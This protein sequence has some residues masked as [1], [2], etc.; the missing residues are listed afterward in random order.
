MWYERSIFCQSWQRWLE[1]WTKYG[2]VLRTGARPGEA[3]TQA[4]RPAS[5]GKGE[6]CREIKTTYYV[7]APGPTCL[8]NCPRS[9]E[10]WSPRGFSGGAGRVAAIAIS[11]KELWARRYRHIQNTTHLSLTLDWL[12]QSVAWNAIFV[13]ESYCTSS[14]IIPPQWPICAFSPREASSACVVGWGLAATN[15]SQRVPDVWIQ[16]IVDGT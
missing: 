15:D 14:G 5:D 7:L 4:G 11:D 2:E 1:V 9:Q 16:N 10:S 6:P 3:G 8:P 13:R 12:R